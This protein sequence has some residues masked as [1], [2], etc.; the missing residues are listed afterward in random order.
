MK[1]LRRPTAAASGTL[2]SP[3]RVLPRARVSL[4][5]L[6]LLA[7]FLSLGCGSTAPAGR[8]SDG[9]PLDPR[10]G[11]PGPFPEGVETG[12][13]AL[14][15]GDAETAEREFL[16]ARAEGRS[17]AAE[18]G[19]IESRTLLGRAKEAA[20]ACNEI[21]TGPVT[22]PLLVAC[23]EARARAG[24]VFE[25][26]EL[27]A[28]AAARD[29]GRSWLRDRSK[30][31]E[32]DAIDALAR[33]ASSGAKEQNY[34]DARK[35]IERAIEMNPGDAGL[36]AMAGDIE[37]AAGEREKA[38]ERFREAYRL[39]PK[40]VPV[41]E[42]LAELAMERDPTLAV[43]VLDELARKDPRYRDRAAAARLSFRI[44]NWPPAEREI[45]RSEKLTRAGAAS[46]VWW[47]FPEIREAR[48]SSSIIASDAVSRKDSPAILRAVSLGLLDVDRG[49]HRARPD[50]GLTRRAVAR[51]LLRLLK[52][53]QRGEPPACLEG[54][55]ESG[56]SGAEAVR[57]AVGCGF[58]ET[59]EGTFVGGEEFTRG[60][61]RVRVEATGKGARR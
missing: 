60:L 36:H 30:E 43:S 61:D 5:L 39:D 1:I 4:P 2:F 32:K 28:R 47:M 42:K 27:Y 16:R 15:A 38:F 31:L 17:L 10:E 54:T 21:L 20:G 37:L 45:A 48:V 57:A 24:Q 14:A 6:G 12:W 56:R 59:E 51:L 33:A 3:L 7:L 35:R 46:L 11:L 52:V 29:P 40:S 50:A 19:L 41:Q 8:R 55:P 18:V 34:P 58:L 26:H 22:V 9:F 49:T 44:S 13:Q 23:G 53:V 25:A